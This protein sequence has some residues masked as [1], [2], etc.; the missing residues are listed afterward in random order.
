MTKADNKRIARNTVFLY[1]RMLLSSGI[2]LYTSRVVLETLGVRDF[3]I[4]N[5]VGG[6][7]TILAFLNGTMSQ[8]TMRFLNYE[9]GIGD[10]QRLK[11]TFGTSLI[12]HSLIALI[13]V[14]FAE[15]VGLWYVNTHLVIEASRM[16]AANWVYQLSILTTVV[17][18][19]Q[20]PFTAA[21]MAHE[22]MDVYAYISLG[23]TFLKLGIVLLLL[24]I[25]AFDN[26]IV[27]ALLFFI[28]SFLVGMCYFIYSVRRFAECRGRIRYDKKQAHKMLKYSGWDIFGNLAYTSR[29]QGSN[30]ILNNFGGTVLN[31]AASLA[32]TVAS[33]LQCFAA[34]VI[35]AF[36]PQVV[37]M[38]ARKEYDEML[39][40]LYNAAKFTVLLMALAVVPIY[41][42]MPALL[43]IW[44][45]DVPEWTVIFCRLC[46]LT[47]IGE[48]LKMA[49]DMGIH[50]TGR[51]FRL[52]F[53][54][55]SML[56]AELP[57]MYYLLQY[58]EWPPMV[59]AIHLVWI[60]AIVFAETLILK[61]QLRE[62]SISKF[63]VRGA[64]MPIAV[65]AVTLA[66]CWRLEV[67]IGQSFGAFIVIGVI[68]TLAIVGLSYLACFDA[69]TRKMVNDKVRSKL[70]KERIKG[71]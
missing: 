62:F 13:L 3:G 40:L 60:F 46:L 66:G 14:V 54:T 58:C 55:G 39:K 6:I 8:A 26:L 34:A 56:L 32:V 22:K 64:F 71:A 31:A 53:I 42:E 35:S 43:A 9:M 21:I 15:T 33:T 17:T 36:R 59:Y 5:L 44:L 29:L 11:G 45:K 51:I 20:I 28:I 30:I 67:A 68:S 38:Y 25:P 48:L 61:Y 47:A 12:I 49:V 24:W 63:W 57:A 19:L 4:Y 65:L 7:V 27:Y 10:P 69:D 70:H 50:A 37:Q 1:V 18:V 2:S 52:S 23:Y 16:A 41:V